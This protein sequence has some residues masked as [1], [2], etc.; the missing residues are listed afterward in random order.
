MPQQPHRLPC[1]PNR[2]F[3]SLY[4][5]TTCE[6][7]ARRHE[8]QGEAGRRRGTGGGSP[9][10]GIFVAPAT[11]MLR[12]VSSSMRCH[13]AR[14]CGQ[15]AMIDAIRS[16]SLSA[17]ISSCAK[18]CGVHDMH[19]NV[20]EWCADEWNA[21]LD[22]QPADGRSRVAGPAGD[23]FRRVIRGGS[24][25]SEERDLRSAFRESS[26]MGSAR[27]DVGFRVVRSING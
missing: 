14:G 22:G 16:D 26:P 27:D 23:P 13:S 19:G 5:F 8:Q 24:W 18:K 7:Q 21:T 6:R 1:S 10:G 9:S 25:R 11:Q 2:K 3:L 17:T 20:W 12:V 4:L 15:S